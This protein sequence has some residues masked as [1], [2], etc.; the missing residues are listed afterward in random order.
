MEI[1]GTGVAVA[2]GMNPVQ[3]LTFSVVI[4]TALGNGAPKVYFQ[5]GKLASA[6]GRIPL[7]KTQPSPK[8]LK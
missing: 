2:S 5:T 3:S 1:Y 7:S 6:A 4:L 8:G